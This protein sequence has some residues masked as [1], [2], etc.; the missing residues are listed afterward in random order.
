M[1]RRCL[2]LIDGQNLFDAARREFGYEWPNFDA[3]KLARLLAVRTAS[4]LCQTRFYSGVP[5]ASVHPWWHA[6]WANKCSQMERND[7][8]TITRAVRMHA[9]GAHAVF[10][11]KEVDLR[12]GLDMV[13]AAYDEEM[14]RFI[15]VSGSGD[16]VEAVREARLVARKAGRR[17]SIASAYPDK[18]CSRQGISQT[19]WLPISAVEHA[20]CLDTRDYSPSFRQLKALTR[21]AQALEQDPQNLVRWPKRHFLQ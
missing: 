10:C 13:R 8:T 20:A 4:A 11:K 17:L 19:E 1:K 12:I 2:V 3:G 15:L 5:A 18:S 7:I 6:F 16:L 14:D 9:E 21:L